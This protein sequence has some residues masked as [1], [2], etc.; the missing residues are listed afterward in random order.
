[1]HIALDHGNI[2]RSRK[3]RQSRK[4]PLRTAAKRSIV[5]TWGQG[6]LLCQISTGSLK[7]PTYAYVC[8]KCGRKFSA[9]MTIT[10][11]ETQRVR[12]PKCGSLRVTQQIA[13]FYAQTS[14]KG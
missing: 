5:N 3:A 8:K 7:M 12:C 11:H 4:K 9:K 2:P 6:V 14:K 1:M 10:E 13:G